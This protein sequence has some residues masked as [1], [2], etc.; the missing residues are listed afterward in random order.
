M[1]K[2]SV[3]IIFL[4]SFVVYLF[5]FN[6][7]RIPLSSKKYSKFIVGVSADYKPM[8]FKDNKNC[9]IGFDIDLIDIICKRLNL[10]YILEDISFDTLI[11]SIQLGRV[12]IGI[13]GISDTPLR[14]KNVLFSK[15]YLNK[16]KV[17]YMTL[18]KNIFIR[19][20]DDLFKYNIVINSGYYYGEELRKI[21]TINLVEL[22]STAEAIQALESSRA[23]IY[24]TGINTCRLIL[25]EKKNTSF[26]F[27]EINLFNIDF[28]TASIA[29]S[30]KNFNLVSIFNEIIEELILDGTIK[31]LCKKWNIEN[32]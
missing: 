17:V 21:D 18:N 24:I 30:K 9:I 8:T 20:Y 32:D 15:P 23:D 25:E 16:E 11:S 27:G 3:I 12:D 26:Y 1:H 7:N 19:S 2:I 4:F 28:S 10:N 6:S 29:F 31:E 14:R 5:Y 13:S 22:S